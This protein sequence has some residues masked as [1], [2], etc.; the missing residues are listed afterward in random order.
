MAVVSFLT[1]PNYLDKA[2]LYKNARL[3][4]PTADAK[5]QRWLI[6]FYVFDAQQGKVVRKRNFECNKFTD[7][8]QRQKFANKFIK[9][10]NEKLAEGFIIDVSKTNI[11]KAKNDI[12]ENNNITLHQALD[13]AI[14]TK[15]KLRPRTH[16]TYADHIKGF[17]EY[18]T[19]DLPLQA[20]N[21]KLVKQFI[22]KKSETLA[23]RSINN[24]I[25][26]LRTMFEVLITEKIITENPWKTITKTKNPR[27]RNIAYTT[28]QQKNILQLMEKKCPELL[29]FCQTMYYTLAR[30]N[31]LC[32]I[33]VKHIDMF[34]PNSLFIPAEI[35]KNNTDR[36]ISLPPPI[37]K[38]LKPIK[39]NCNGNHFIFGRGIIPGPEHL[40]AKNVAQSYSKR[41]LSKFNLGSD[42]TLYSWK[43]TGVVTNYINGMSPA[44]LRM[45]IGHND[46]GSFETYL[47]SL[48]MMENKEVM[49][50]YV[51]LPK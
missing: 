37:Y 11:D 36:H 3:V 17:K 44:A 10:V 28:E 7:L 23:I 4:I 24:Y 45:Q 50:N 8:N 29:L 13:F 9:Q 2:T 6:I 20:C 12:L 41:V 49:D 39:D 42:Y 38:L 18:T 33:K 47:K 46:T 25:G 14:S 35:S 34:K 51:E 27:G 48:G 1:E 26:S 43:H 15:T 40:P 16:K 32:H 5:D 31:E 21:E 19:S 30:P 22:K